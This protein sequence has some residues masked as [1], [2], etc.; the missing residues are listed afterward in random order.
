LVGVEL[1]EDGNRISGNCGRRV[2]T[3]E[4]IA[5]GLRIYVL[6]TYYLCQR[7]MREPRPFSDLMS[8][9]TAD[10]RFFLR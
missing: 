9:A 2:H 10:G 4:G 5:S 8:F 7:R 1:P 3:R 6:A